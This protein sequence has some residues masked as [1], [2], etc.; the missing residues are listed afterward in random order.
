MNVK[1]PAEVR[2]SETL[3][4]LEQALLSPLVS[5]EIHQWLRTV[6]DAAAT[7]SVDLTALLRTV[8]HVKY[9]EI[10]RNA[11]ELSNQLTKLTEAD[12]NL[13][14]S[15]A[16]FLEQ[17]YRLG[18]VIEKADPQKMETMLEKHRQQTVEMGLA[19][20]MSIRKQQAAAETWYE[21][22][23]FRDIGTSAD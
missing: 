20:I 23:Q 2:I 16:S 21:E 6:Q 15:V 3:S 13:L 22:A 11:P 19:L 5:G 14:G 9:A 18:E 10:A 17:L 4:T 1:I 7:L 8:L 12:G